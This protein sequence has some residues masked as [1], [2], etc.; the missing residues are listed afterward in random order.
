MK[1]PLLS[2]ATPL[3]IAST[4]AAVLTTTPAR[5]DDKAACI[6]ANS[7]GQRFRDEHKLV[8]AREQLRICAAAHCPAVIQTDCASWLAEVEKALP[9]VVVTAKNGAGAYLVDVKVSVDGQPLLSKLDG[10][11]VPLNAGPHAFHFEGADGTSVDQQ[12]FVREGDKNQ[13]VTAVLGEPARAP[14]GSNAHAVEPV[15]PGANTDTSANAKTTSSP[16]KT[17]G[18]VT[19]GVG[20]VGLGLGAAFG[21]IAMGDKSGAHCDANNVC[22]PGSTSGIKSAA[23]VSDIGWIAGGVLVATGAALLLF[24]P[25][26]APASAGVRITPVVTASGGAVVVGGAW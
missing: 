3:A 4:L 24:A 26:G 21:L 25:S 9:G 22:D 10:R 17:V 20:V 7:K 6:D 23:L 15:K 1:T 12:V 19:G 5:A 14:S 2:L 18:W 8:E 13:P 16:L 11:A